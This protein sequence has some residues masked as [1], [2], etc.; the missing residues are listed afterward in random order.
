MIASVL[1]TAWLA[2]L[3]L[4]SDCRKCDGTG[5]APCPREA[6]HACTG[7]AALHCSIAI[8]CAECVGTQRVACTKCKAEPGLENAAARAANRTWQVGLAS[9]DDVL[10]RPLAHAKSAHFL[11]TF[12]IQGLDVKGGGTR[13]DGMHLYLDRLEELYWRVSSDLGAEDDDYLG[14]TH[15]LLWSQRA[16]QEKAALAFTRQSSSTESKLMGKAPVVSIFYDKQWLHEEF[17]LHQAMV[18]QVAHCLLSNVWD[19][20]WPGNIRA[21]WLDEGLAHVYE[22]ELFGEVRHYCYVEA[23]TILDIQRG[24]WEPP[25]RAAV[26]RDEAPGF[27]GVAGKNTTELTREDQLFAWS[28]V[29]FVRR[30]HPEQLGPLARALKAKKTLVVTLGETLSLSPFQFEDAWRDFVQE[31]YALKE[32]KKKRKRGRR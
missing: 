1:I 24:S 28:Y 23:D 14:P 10:G 4:A 26:D 9:I 3:G 32:R 20:I 5:L 27:V 13:H 6:R 30:A 21:G 29:D 12:D 22:M 19:G 8:E 16:D 17:E 2:L 11:L 15:V 18:H 7:T 25:V 31:N